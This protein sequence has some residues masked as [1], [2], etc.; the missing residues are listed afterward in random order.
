MSEIL[1][2][3]GYVAVFCGLA[4]MWLG[5]MI[6]E[7]FFGGLGVFMVFLGFIFWSGHLIWRG[8]A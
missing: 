4:C 2:S 8:R 1:K 5:L 3:A 7:P 6:G